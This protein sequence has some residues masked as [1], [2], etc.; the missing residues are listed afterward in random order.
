[1]GSTA[2]ASFVAHVT[3]WVLLVCG[4]VA[5][6]LSGTAALAL[7]VLWFVL[8]LGL[9]YVPYGPGVF[10]SVVAVLDIVLVL[11]IFKGDVRIA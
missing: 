6:E 7:A 8:P 2:I 1:M 5:R 10:P 3:F 9:G 11:I 4:L